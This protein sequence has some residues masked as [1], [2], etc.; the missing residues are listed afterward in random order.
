MYREES[1][2]DNE[3]DESE[4]VDTQDFGEEFIEDI[5]D[6]IGKRLKQDAWGASNCKSYSFI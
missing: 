1:D 2:I 5:A 4:E 6:E 3:N